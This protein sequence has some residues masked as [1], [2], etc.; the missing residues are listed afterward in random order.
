MRKANS[1]IITLCE[2]LVIPSCEVCLLCRVQIPTRF[3]KGGFKMGIIC[4]LGSLIISLFTLIMTIILMFINEESTLSKFY[5]DKEIYI[6]RAGDDFVGGAAGGTLF[7]HAS[8]GGRTSSGN[9]PG[10]RSRHRGY[11]IA[12]SY[13]KCVHPLGLWL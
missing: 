5:G 9:N 10:H 3:I 8:Q 1:Q 4:Y 6:C 11:H 12:A 7:L 2:V 13:G